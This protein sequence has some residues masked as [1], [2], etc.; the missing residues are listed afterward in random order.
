RLIWESVRNLYLSGA[1]ADHNAL[2]PVQEP[3]V[4]HL[5]LIIEGRRTKV[6]RH[7]RALCRRGLAHQEPA[8]D[9]LQ[10]AAPAHESPVAEIERLQ[11]LGVLQLVCSRE[12]NHPVLVEHGGIKPAAWRGQGNGDVTLPFLAK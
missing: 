6:I 11:P 12:D 2:A 3:P 4:R 10:K 5:P 7:L 8:G 9:N 1:L